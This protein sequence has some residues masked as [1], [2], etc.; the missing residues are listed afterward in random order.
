MASG[1]CRRPNRFVGFRWLE[2]V[3][4]VDRHIATTV[5]M[6]WCQG[7]GDVP[8]PIGRDSRRPNRP[9]FSEYFLAT[10]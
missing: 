6:V 10:L 1:R 2:L 8:L 4:D 3:V 7:V 9:W 5:S